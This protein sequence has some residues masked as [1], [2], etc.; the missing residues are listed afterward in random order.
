[1]DKFQVI[2]DLGEHKK[3]NKNQ[4]VKHNRSA[5]VNSDNLVTNNIISVANYYYTPCKCTLTFFLILLLPLRARVPAF[6]F[7]SSS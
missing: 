7:D 1:M 3:K 2:N 4:H 6:R 5:Q